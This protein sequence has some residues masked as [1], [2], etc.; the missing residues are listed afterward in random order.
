MN[1]EHT[2]TTKLATS[3]RSDSSQSPRGKTHTW[4]P[5]TERTGCGRRLGSQMFTHNLPAVFAD[6]LPVRYALCSRCF[7]E[8]LAAWKANR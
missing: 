2:M 3:L 5:E 6:E 1:K 8:E 7:A 4:D